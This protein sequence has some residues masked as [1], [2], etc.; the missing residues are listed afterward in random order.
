MQR[1]SRRVT[2]ASDVTRNAKDMTNAGTSAVSGVVS[3]A[4]GGHPRDSKAVEG[5]CGLSRSRPEGRAMLRQGSRSS[6]VCDR[7]CCARRGRLLDRCHSSCEPS[8]LCGTSAHPAMQT[9]KRRTKGLTGILHKCNLS[10]RCVGVGL[11][12]APIF[13]RNASGL[14]ERDSG[15]SFFRG[16]GLTAATRRARGLTSSSVRGFSVMGSMDWKGTTL[17]CSSRTDFADCCPWSVPAFRE[18]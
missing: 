4:R 16:G 18:V 5:E 12:P 11:E 2:P 14:R 1:R 3:G 13:G 6:F 9:E 17:E 10:K 7:W 15:E 8:W